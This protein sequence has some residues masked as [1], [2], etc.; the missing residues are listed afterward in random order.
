MKDFIAEGLVATV[1]FI[2]EWLLWSSVLFNLG[3]ITLLLCTLGRYPRG[4]ALD[5][6]VNRIALVGLLALVCLWSAIAIY[7]NLRPAQQPY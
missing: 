6:D 5:R 4:D 7:N 1:K 2:F 3:R